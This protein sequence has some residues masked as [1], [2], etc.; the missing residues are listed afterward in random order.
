ME[1]TL[2]TKFSHSV[3]LVSVQLRYF[4][5]SHRLCIPLCPLCYVPYVLCHPL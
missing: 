1:I 4:P 3:F 2:M 5:T